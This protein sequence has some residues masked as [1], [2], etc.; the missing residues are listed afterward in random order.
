MKRKNFP[1][2][3]IR[4]IDGDTVEVL[5]D[6]GL[7]VFHLTRIRLA[8]INA[9]ELKSSDPDTRALALE[10][11]SFVATFESKP[12]DIVIASQDIYGRYIADVFCDELDIGAEMVKIGLAVTVDYGDFF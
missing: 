1:A 2:K 9:P 8:G 5:V 6:L 11:K 3:I 12:C 4:A 7:S 10:A